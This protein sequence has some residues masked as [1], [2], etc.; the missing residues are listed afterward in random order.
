L[1][2]PA[3]VIGDRVAIFTAWYFHRMVKDFRNQELLGDPSGMT[4]VEQAHITLNYKDG[5]FF[6]DNQLCYANV[7]FQRK[8]AS[9]D[10]R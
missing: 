5:Q 9:F 2:G 3:E 10:E 1:I 7:S 8:R 4:I 6:D